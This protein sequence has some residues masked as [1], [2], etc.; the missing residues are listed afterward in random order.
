MELTERVEELAR[1][2][3]RSESEILEEA[4]EKGVKSLWDEYILSQYIEGE[5]DRAEA[6]KLVG[7]AKVKR[8]D[9]EM[10]AVKE[11]IEW[12]MEA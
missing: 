3:E 2:Q 1:E 8:A 10:E 7:L 9:R 5:L 4:L 6:V 12:G 11:D